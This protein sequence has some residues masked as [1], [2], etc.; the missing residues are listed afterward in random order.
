MPRGPDEA[1]RYS[2][3]IPP[4][5]YPR[6]ILQG[7][8]LRTFD[9]ACAQLGSTVTAK[10]GS[11]DA[12]FW[13]I[14]PDHTKDKWTRRNSARPARVEQ[15]VREILFHQTTSAFLASLVMGFCKD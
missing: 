3:S 1:Y 5:Q 6:Q 14:V 2:S 13:S 15:L 9:L 7:L 8:H 10:N 11:V 12:D 4:F